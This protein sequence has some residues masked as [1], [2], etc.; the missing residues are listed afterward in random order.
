MVDNEK[1]YIRYSIHNSNST[2]APPNASYLPRL[3]FLNEGVRSVNEGVP[4][5]NSTYNY[6]YIPPVHTAPGASQSHSSALN[7]NNANYTP[8]QSENLHRH[9]SSTNPAYVS[10]RQ[11]ST[12]GTR[13]NHNGIHGSNYI[14]RHDPATGDIGSGISQGNTLQGS[15]SYPPRMK[16]TCDCCNHHGNRDPGYLPKRTN[17][18]DSISHG[19]HGPHFL[20]EDMGEEAALR[21][22]KTAN[23]I[24][25]SPEL[26]EKLYLSPQTQ[27][28]G[29]LRKTFANPTPIA[30]IGYI[31]A[32]V[33]LSCDLMGF[34][35][36]GGGIPVG[37]AGVGSYWF[38]GGALMLLGGILEF[39]LGNTFSSVVF[40]SYGAYWFSYAAIFTPA[41]NAAIPYDPANPITAASS[42]GFSSAWAFFLLFMGILSF[43]YLICSLR[44]NIMFVIVFLS[45]QIGFMVEAG[46][47]WAIASGNNSLGA[48]L[49]VASGA[50]YFVGTL[51]GF[52]VFISQLLAS[53]DFPY[54]L[55]VGD[56]SHIIK[57]YSEKAS[58]AKQYPV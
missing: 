3:N 7:S 29:D 55:P 19:I 35:G 56:I 25:I 1:D 42:P 41:F 31:I 34:R 4:N 23:S 40:C 28:K 46:A 33:P 27:V 22:M 17:S 20:Q 49:F 26:F 6:N 24:S 39:I 43:I 58:N 52:E 12:E 14:S 16:D 54:Q 8:R 50:S 47:Y 38:F 5:R 13:H 44:T 48:S 32:L 2:P 21:K 36:A 45:L 57:G 30:L 53:V 15:T 51:A 9:E 18:S 11:N 37:A 10:R